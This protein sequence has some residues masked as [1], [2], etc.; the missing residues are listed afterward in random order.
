MDRATQVAVNINGS[1][2]E[3][4]ASYDYNEIGQLKDKKLGKINSGANAGNFLQTVDYRYNIRGW[5]TSINNSTLTF[6][7][8][9]TNSST[10]DIWGETILYD[11]SDATGL[12]NT[13]RY[14]G[15]ISVIK[16]QVNDQFSVSANPVRQRSYNYTYDNDDRFLNANYAAY[17]TAS[18]SW[19][20]ET[21]GYNEA[22]NSY[23]Y[24]GNIQFLQR[25]SWANGATSATTI[26]NLQYVYQNSNASNQLASVAD[27]T[28]NTMGFNDRSSTAN[29][30]QFD[31]NGSLLF[32]ANKNET[33]TYNDINLVSKVTIP[34]TGSIEY[35]YDASGIRIRRIVYNSSGSA[36][37]TYDYMDGFQYLNNALV[38]FNTSE[39]RVLSYGSFIYEYFI[40]DH[41]NNVRLSFQDNGS[42]VA[43]IT[44]DNEYYPFGMTMQ[45]IVV[46]TGLPTTENRQLFNGGSELQDDF[47]FENG[48][49]TPCR[50]YDDVLGKFNAIDPMVDKY[51]AITPYNF[52]FN[53]PVTINDP[54][55]ADGDPNSASLPNGTS[56]ID[57]FDPTPPVFDP[58]NFFIT[59]AQQSTQGY[60]PAQVSWRSSMSQDLQQIRIYQEMALDPVQQD[61]NGS[62]IWVENN[63]T[64]ATTNQTIVE[65]DKFHLSAN[66]GGDPTSV[67]PSSLGHNIFYS[68]YIGPWNPVSY[69]GHWNYQ[70]APINRADLGALRHDKGY[71]KLGITGASG[72]FF[73]ISALPYD[74]QLVKYEY[75][76]FSNPNNGATFTERMEGLAVGEGIGISIIPK[77]IYN[78][79]NQYFQSS[80]AQTPIGYENVTPAFIPGH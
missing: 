48:Y 41:L 34:G 53:D 79:I 12:S 46:R 37:N 73:N 72:V 64:D 15:Q 54:M 47:G 55:G 52:A 44:Q 77:Q 65:A 74:E 63:H 42:G 67:N 11:Q 18:S 14:N 17:N 33:I 43:K 19:N 38:S 16:W 4:I 10:D 21:A 13:P 58:H 59:T 50:E 35:D 25:N 24:N 9:I 78:A 60:Q 8:G 61:S 28:G 76:L 7:N 51:A 5:I 22:V 57:P 3:V 56:T 30:Y 40:K 70:A 2:D 20:L 68:N 71:D 49:S 32:D 80:P 62:Y 66:Q 6:D 75:G 26:D 36:V 45:G 69:N 27:I 39:G 29:E 23:D 31:G 1:A